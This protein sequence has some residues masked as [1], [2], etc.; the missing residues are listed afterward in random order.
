M[1]VS[2]A[3]FGCK[4]RYTV[5]AREKGITFHRFPKSNPVLLDKW[6]LA[7]RRATSTGQLWMPSRYQRLCSLHFEESCFD[8][9]GQTKRL[10]DDVIPSIFSFPSELQLA[11]AP[12]SVRLKMASPSAPSEPTPGEAVNGTPKVETAPANKEASISSQVQ[13]QDHIYFIPDVETLKRKLRASED[14]RVQ[15]EKELRNAKDR[16]KRLRQTCPSIYQELGKKNLLTPHLQEMLQSYGDIPLELF[17]KPE[18]EYSVQQRLF[19]LTLQLYNPGA[20]K[21]LRNTIKLPL[22]SA[23]KLRQWLKTYCDKPGLNYLVLEALLKKKKE[24]PPLYTRA[25]LVVDTMSIQQHI[26]FDSQQ[27][28]LVGFVNLGKGADASGSQEVASEALVLMLVGIA[29]HWKAPIAYFFIKSLT[30]EAQKQLVLHALH[31][32]SDNGFEIVAVSMERHQRNE[33]MCTLLGCQ[34]TDPR[35]L[36]TYFSLPDSEHKHYVLFDVSNE[37]Q[38]IRDMLKD[39]GTI[40]SPDGTIMWQYIDNLMSMHK[41]AAMHTGS[42]QLSSHVAAFSQLPKITLVVN[43]LSNTVAQALAMLQELKYEPFAGCTATVSFIQI[44]DRLSDILTSKSTRVKGDKG[45]VNRTNL[46]HK[47][48]VLQETKEYLLTLTTSDNA[49]LYKCPSAQCILGLLVNITS[50]MALLPT[51][52]LDQ[53]YVLTHRFSPDHLKIFLNGIQKADGSDNKPTAMN[54]KRAIRRLLSQCGVWNLY[55]PQQNE[56]SFVHITEDDRV[57]CSFRQH[58]ASP[59]QQN[60]VMLPDHYYSSRVLNFMLQNSEVYI[61]GWVVR[62]AFSQL[63]CDKCR[64]AL[65]TGDTPQD[66]RNAYHL[67]QSKDGGAFVP[68]TGTIKTVL[69]A[70]KE[71]HH[72]LNYQTFKHSTFPLVLEHHVLSLL[73][74]A[75]IF[76]L[77][78]HITLTELGIDNHHFQLLRL[79]TSLYCALRQAYVVK[80][81]QRIQYQAHVTKILT[82]PIHVFNENI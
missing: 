64:W 37:Q 62:K 44:I 45:P 43:T 38:M 75:D 10:R 80:V 29:G 77:K 52:L 7:I 33:E 73:G 11:M 51:L 14:S 54:L 25:C 31:E 68:S 13:L 35:E 63:A 39:P 56:I 72:M 46:Q 24:N 79:I 59:F 50:F 1:P 53:A 48:D 30:P 22:P 18:C 9:T 2:C 78:E 27:N 41:T 69:T 4:S 57:P 19:A 67:L 17:M 23:R 81:T 8:T 3:A 15:K 60:S 28:E 16:E 21:Y 76:D 49:C 71:L 42:N 6:R 34:F 70:E 65:V 74:S 66:F 5:E 55:N 40:Q 36:Q 47:L 26:T 20:Y 58:L 61:T 32:L 12:A 82:K